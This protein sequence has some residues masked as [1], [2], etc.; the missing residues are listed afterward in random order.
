MCYSSNSNN[1]HDN[2]LSDWE[3]RQD[4]SPN[5]EQFGSMCVCMYVCMCVCVCIYIYIYIHIYIYIWKGEDTV[6]NPHRA[7]IC[8]FEFFEF[9]L[10][11]KLDKRLS[12]ER[13]E[14]AVSQSTVPS[15]SFECSTM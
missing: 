11:L 3:K 14:A 5:K 2:R 9:I 1:K 13:F 7:Q 15:P 8:Q 6:G 10:L 4:L 12:V